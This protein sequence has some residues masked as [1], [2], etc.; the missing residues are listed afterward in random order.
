MADLFDEVCVNRI[1]EMPLPVVSS[2]WVTPGL[3]AART[4]PRMNETLPSVPGPHADR[5]SLNVRVDV[6]SVIKNAAVS[7]KR[8]MG[9]CM[10]PLTPHGR[11]LRVR[12]LREWRRVP[13]IA[14]L[15]ATTLSACVSHA[16]PGVSISSFSSPGA[17]R[18]HVR[19]YTP[20][21]ALHPRRID[22]AGPGLVV[23]GGGTDVDAEFVWMH[24]TVVGSPSRRGGDV[25]V[26][27]ATGSDDYDGY[28][29]RLAPFHSVRT[30]KLPPCATAQEVEQAAR[31]VGRSS[32]VFFAGGDQA[33]YVIWKNT[34]LQA[35]VQG[36][37]ERGGVVGGTSAGAAIL[38]R[39]VFDAVAEGDL[40]TTTD[41][42]VHD[43]YER[44]ISFTYGF[45]RFPALHD[46]ITDMHFV[47]RNR[48]GREAVFVAR[49]IADGLVKKEPPVAYGL[50]VDEASAVAI[51]KHG[52]GTL[53]LQGSG[54]SAYAIES[55]AARR[56]VRGR[57][58][59][60]STLLV[61]RLGTQGDRFDFVRHCGDEPSY[62]VTVD[63][64]RPHPQMYSPHDPYRVP[65]QAHVRP[66]APSL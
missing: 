65:P 15:A 27:R 48:F 57:P 32:I 43:P 14:L 29:Y 41:N 10:L 30:I 47:T 26:L 44:R 54:G 22:A 38:G 62:D 36:V 8:K 63:G 9:D 39:D 12:T 55:H 18:C 2:S 59:V 28:I 16:L 61:T 17:A 7:A 56:I 53:L 4:W 19:F 20:K 33:D 1:V 45:L 42:A 6:V 24:D 50:G 21:G 35:A 46:T 13:L 52:V 25:V 34:P 5:A 51:D 3:L 37:Y 23:A 40:Q 60:S 58:F 64:D 66:C 11:F 31:I 49:Q